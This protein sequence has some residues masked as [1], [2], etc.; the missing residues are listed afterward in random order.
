MNSCKLQDCR[1]K[2]R[3][4]HRDAN[5]KYFKV[6]SMCRRAYLATELPWVAPVEDGRIE[7]IMEDV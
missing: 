1:E 5:I 3:V 7:G 6:Q 2:A 4:L